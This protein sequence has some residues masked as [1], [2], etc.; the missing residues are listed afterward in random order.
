M[1]HAV[2]LAHPKPESFC[3]AL[4][5][6]CVDT[7]ATLGHSARLIDLYALDFDP[8]LKASELPG[9]HGV[10]PAEDVI[11]E[12]RRLADV[13]NLIFV[14]PFWF[15]A[16]PAMLKGYV[17]RVFGMGFGYGPGLGGNVPLLTDRTLLSLSTSGAPDAWV[18]S[19]HALDNLMT[20]F[21]RHL[22]G[23]C[24]L[25]VRDHWHFGG[26][27]GLMTK[28]AAQQVVESVRT[29]LGDLFGVLTAAT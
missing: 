5:R 25:T 24:G 6:T 26:V 3:G 11:A 13:D 1:N 23:V 20:V 16:P 28:E 29:D 10:I 21:D 17:D 19:T 22:A 27:H 15:N 8:R 7:L 14:Y 4:A 12:R 9:P 18:A 2:I